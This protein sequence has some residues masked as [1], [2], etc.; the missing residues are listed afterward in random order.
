MDD[1]IKI[2]QKAVLE[3]I[4]AIAM[5]DATK[6]LA[7]RDGELEVR[8]TEQLPPEICAAICSIEKSG[9]SLKVKF[10]DKLKALELLGKHLG[11]FDH[12]DTQPEHDNNLLQT[13]LDSTKEVI[14]TDDLPE[15]QQAA[16]AGNDLVEQTQF[17][18]S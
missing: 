9:G 8:T 1:T 3:Q 2:S 12:R 10:Y 14:A 11:L 13:I 6:V 18:A 5:A 4:G 15:V 16:A 7:I 17:E